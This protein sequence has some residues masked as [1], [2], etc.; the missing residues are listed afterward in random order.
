MSY[1]RSTTRIK[2]LVPKNP[3]IEKN[4]DHD[5]TKAAFVTAFALCWP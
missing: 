1:L 3:S 4:A 5:C 2:R